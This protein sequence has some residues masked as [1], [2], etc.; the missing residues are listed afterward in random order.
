[1]KTFLGIVVAAG[2]SAGVAFFMAS[3][4]ATSRQADLAEQQAA[5]QSERV[6][7]E[8]ALAEAKSRPPQ[9]IT[10]APGVTTSTVSVVPP[11]M[12]PA[13]IVAALRA[14]KVGPGAPART[15]RQALYWFEDLIAAGPSAL[16]A[17]REFLAR[18]ED[19]EFDAAAVPKGR[20]GVPNSFI[21]PPSLRFGLLDVVKQIGGVEGERLLAETMSRTGRGMEVAW[22]ARTLQEMAPN[23]YRDA[24]LAAAREL[25]AR[26]VAAGT[27]AANDRNDRDQLFS[28]LLMYGDTS[29]ASTAQTQ[30]F[31]PDGQLDRSTL[32]YL[33]QSLGAQS[34]AVAAQLYDDPRLGG[35]GT[36]EPLARLALNFVGA[37]AQAN[38]FYYKAIND[39]TLTPGQ[40]KNLIEDL[41]ED[42]FP[43]RKNLTA[44]DL[45]LIENR[46]SL[47]EQVAPAA[48]DPA[49]IAAFKEAYKDLVNMRER[50]LRPPPTPA[51]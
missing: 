20:S 46:L 14:L 18:N 43:D 7:L 51:K 10:A 37:D 35:S 1:M 31:R 12:A 23:S 30:L 44:R 11:R 3:K 15:V 49:N 27:G 41:N 21:I 28:V 26:P 29:Y 16:P 36:K 25:L 8:E 24:A 33:Q 9:L 47:I 2:L 39:M 6:A 50:V 34:V 22:L 48:T 4:R 40:R 5:W 42:G 38:E 19:S 45:P 13:Q 17:I 32:D